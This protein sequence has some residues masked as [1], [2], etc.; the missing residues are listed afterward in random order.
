MIR[1][2]WFAVFLVFVATRAVA[3]ERAVQ[4]LLPSRQLE[5]TSTSELRFANEMVAA[6][7]IGKPAAL[8]PLVFSPAVEGQFI[9]L[10]SRSAMLD[11]G[12]RCRSGVTRF[13]I[14]FRSLFLRGSACH[15][16]ARRR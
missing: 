8:S 2:F 14:Y 12:G 9:W 16:E 11:E 6:D 1:P 13:Q 3:E 4:L 15:P 5:P 7:Q 10:S